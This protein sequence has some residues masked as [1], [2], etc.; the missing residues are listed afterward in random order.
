MVRGVRFEKIMRYPPARPVF[1]DP[2]QYGTVAA[3]STMH[4]TSLDAVTSLEVGPKYERVSYMPH[5]D[6]CFSAAS[7]LLKRPRCPICGEEMRLVRLVPVAAHM[8]ERTSQ[9]PTW[10]MFPVEDV[11]RSR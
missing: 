10:D 2:N 11:P 7:V 6:I 4:M 1:V 8:V 5:T 3:G 9:C